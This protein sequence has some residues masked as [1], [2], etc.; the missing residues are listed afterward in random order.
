MITRRL[1][2]EL[3]P[4]VESE[5]LSLTDV[6]VLWKMER[7]KVCRVSEIAD[8]VGASPSTFTGVLD[9]LVAGGWLSRS[10]DPNDRRAVLVRT[11]PGVRPLLERLRVEGDERL[12]KV[13]RSI[14]DGRLGAIV[15]SMELLLTSL[16]SDDNPKDGR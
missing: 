13:F 9:R 10:P 14:P 2:R 1:A 6:F 16:Q 5:N 15:E 11:T 3:S 8:E 4:L 12:G 7:K